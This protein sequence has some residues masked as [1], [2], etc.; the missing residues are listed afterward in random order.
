MFV[1]LSPESIESHRDSGPDP[2]QNLDEKP[3]KPGFWFPPTA[4]IVFYTRVRSDPKFTALYDKFKKS[5]FFACLEHT[6]LRLVG[7]L[8]YEPI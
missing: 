8:I 7:W 3:G 4:A 6:S 2:D 1:S 5:L